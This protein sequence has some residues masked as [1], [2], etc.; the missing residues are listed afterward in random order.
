MSGL[1]FII[2]CPYCNK[3]FEWRDGKVQ[4]SI[5]LHCDSCEKELL[6][7]DEPEAHEPFYKQC[8]CCG[9]FEKTQR[10]TI[11][12]PEQISPRACPSSKSR[13]SRNI[14]GRPN[15]ARPTMIASTP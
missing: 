11:S 1:T 2:P 7:P 10:W 8:E 13:I 9:Y 3:T 4:N 14:Q 15:V 6:A 5:I 12:L